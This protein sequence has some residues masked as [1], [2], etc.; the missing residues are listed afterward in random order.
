[1]GG[2][3]P[4]CYPPGPPPAVEHRPVAPVRVGKD[5]NWGPIALFTLVGLVAAGI[6]GW[7]AFALL[8]QDTRPFDERAAEIEGVVNWYDEH[9]DLLDASHHSGPVQYE[10]NPPAGGPHNE[11]WQECSGV[12]YDD[13]I[14]T[15]HALHSLEHGAVWVT[16]D[17]A[18]LSDSDV[19][20]LARNVNNTNYT[21]MS[22]FD[23][24]DAPISLQAWGYQLKLESAG[25]PRIQEFIRALRVNASLEGPAARCDGGVNT[26]GTTPISAAGGT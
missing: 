17:P 2:R 19:D 5:R 14:P 9:P 11:R 24:Q 4:P 25:D 20:R 23:G 15:E 16:Y 7:A 6:V 12:V 26:T 1:L 10:I 8:D 18:V 21:L 22:Q 3:D 13:R